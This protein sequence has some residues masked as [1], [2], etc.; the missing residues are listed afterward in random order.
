MRKHTSIFILGTLLQFGICSQIYAQLDG[1]FKK[2]KDK[3]TSNSKS[4]VKTIASDLTSDF[5]AGDSLL[6]AEDFSSYKT[7]SSAAS[8]KTNG[9]AT[10][11]TVEDQKG[12]WM[13]LQDKAIYKLSK[14]RIY[15]GHF[16]VEF[17]ILAL[18]EQV[19]DIAPLSFGFVADNSAREYNSNAGAY[20]QLH[21]Y[22]ANQA[23]VGSTTLNKFINA[24]FDLSS[25]LNR[26]LHVSLEIQGER[27]TVYLDKTKLADTE[28][29]NKQEAKNFYI[30]APW[31][32]ENGSR[33]LISNLRIATFKK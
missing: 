28:L 31:Q 6:V 3:I 21:Y 5:E 32:Y 4:K 7:G 23:N 9:T 11:T 33:V 17:D 13:V 16:T 20:V 10:V 25:A 30:T 18:G 1:L 29:F 8:F 12:K 27:V 19:K 22:D 24:S 15:P 14:Q 2:A 26:P